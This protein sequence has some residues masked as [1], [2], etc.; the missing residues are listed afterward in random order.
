MTEISFLYRLIQHES[1]LTDYLDH[2]LDWQSVFAV[3]YTG[4]TLY[5]CFQHPYIRHIR[6]HFQIKDGVKFSIHEAK[7]FLEKTRHHFG[8]ELLE[9]AIFENFKTL[10]QIEPIPYRGTL[11][12]IDRITCDADI[13]KAL[14]LSKWSLYYNYYDEK[15]N[16]G[17]KTIETEYDL[18]PVSEYQYTEI[19]ADPL[20]RFKDSQLEYLFAKTN[21]PF[22]YRYI[23]AR[24]IARLRSKCRAICRSFRLDV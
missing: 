7:Q 24:R 18:I 16:T 8:T 20:Q 12:L 22:F 14:E 5:H 19:Q 15:Q 13:Q 10:Q 1:G 21:L 11:A 17:A 6:K 23:L 9:T 2:F 4:K 3:K